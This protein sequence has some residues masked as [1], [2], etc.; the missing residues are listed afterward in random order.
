MSDEPVASSGPHSFMQDRTLL[1]VYGRSYGVAPI[2]GMLGAMHSLDEMEQAVR[3][4]IEGISAV[5][6]NRPIILAPHLLYAVARDCQDASDACL[7]FLDASGVD[8]VSEYIKPT[9]ERG[10]AVI[11]DVQIG[12]LTPLA[13]VR[14][15]IDAG[16]LAYPHVH[17]A[18]DPEF[19]TQPGQYHP[20]DP[21]GQLP[22]DLINQAQELLSAY[23]MDENL[24]L[25]KV[26]IVHQ[27]VDGQTNRWS[28]IP[29]KR[30]IQ[31][32]PGVEL[33]IDADGFGSPDAKVW[34]YNAMTD[35]LA[36]PWLRW[37]GIK[38]FQYNRHAPR[39]SDN[40][41]MT[42]RQVY[43]LDPTPAGRS[44]WAGP[45]LIVVA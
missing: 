27:F 11:L 45:H 4:W 10:M 8:I 44:M 30:N 37:R 15:M 1:T 16:Y 39:F 24:P 38:I 21:I 13:L 7:I 34:K 17:L 22:A 32:F 43:G 40:P 20:G 9:E 3:P 41:V 36:Y 18:L 12:R 33:I 42:A 25:C 19:A 28:M 35:P 6:D 31:Q 5:T 2:L 29:D 23:A 26:L 14:R